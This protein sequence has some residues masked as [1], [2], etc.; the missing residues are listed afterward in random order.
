L[1]EVVVALTIGSENDLFPSGDQTAAVAGAEDQ[2]F[3][4]ER[5]FAKFDE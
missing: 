5:M 2:S 1:I 3:L 4:Q